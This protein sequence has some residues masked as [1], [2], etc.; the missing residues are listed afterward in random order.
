MS[1][2]VEFHVVAV[3]VRVESADVLARVVGVDG[4][5]MCVAGALDEMV[6]SAARLRHAVVAPAV[7]EVPA[8]MSTTRGRVACHR[9]VLV[10]FA[11]H[12]ILAFGRR[13]VAAVS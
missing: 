13:V 1:G 5:P 3:V 8:E 9:V 4:R 11:V 7:E 10:A 12:E 6:S 2:A